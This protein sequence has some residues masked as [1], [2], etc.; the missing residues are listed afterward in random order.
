MKRYG[1]L[2]RAP[3]GQ[4]SMMLPVKR[5]SYWSP[6]SVAISDRGAPVLHGQQPVLGDV[7]AEAHAAPARDAALAVERDQRGEV[8]RLGE[9]ALGL[10]EARA[11]GAEREGAVLEGALA[12]LVAHRAVERVV[13]EQ[14]L[15][16]AVLAVLRELRVGAHDHVGLHG[17]AARGLEAAHALDLDQAHAAGAHGRAEARLVAEDRD[18]DPVG[19]G[20]V[21]E[22]R[23]GGRRD[24][25]AVELEL[26]LP[27]GGEVNRSV[28][29]H[30]RAPPSWARGGA[31]RPPRSPARTRR[32]S[33]APR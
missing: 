14:E 15:E 18:L 23:P 5:P 17:R 22:H 12:A 32:G 9:V 16:H 28:I 25:A 30:R 4:M 31:T 6:V 27:L 33:G 20:R 7:L 13:L 1:M 29:S 8:E 19:V 10:D 26:H 21:H 24:P 3:T 11:P 2:V